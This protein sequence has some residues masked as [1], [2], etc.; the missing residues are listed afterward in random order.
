M[1]PSAKNNGREAIGFTRGREDLS[2]HPNIAV[3]AVL[4][5]CTDIDIIMLAKVRLEAQVVQVGPGSSNTSL[6]MDSEVVQPSDKWN[7]SSNK[8]N[9]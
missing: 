1:T 7:F 6:Q 9:F 8:C 2:Q 5:C 3:Q 4:H